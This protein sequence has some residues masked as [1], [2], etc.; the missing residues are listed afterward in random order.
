MFPES[1]VNRYRSER[2][3]GPRP[4]RTC[5]G[6]R[7]SLRFAATGGILV[8]DI[9]CGRR[10][11]QA[12]TLLGNDMMDPYIVAKVT[13]C[14]TVRTA[15]KENDEKPHFNERFVFTISAAD[16]EAGEV[17]LKLFDKDTKTTD[18]EMANVTFT[19]LAPNAQMSE[20]LELVA[21]TA[22]FG[23]S[24]ME[25]VPVLDVN[26][27]LIPIKDLLAAP[28]LL[29]KMDATIKG[30]QASAES[31]AGSAAAMREQLDAMAVDDA[32]DEEAKA[33]L[34]ASL[35]QLE[36][37]MAAAQAADVAALEE[38][39]AAEAA[40]RDELA[41]KI[42]ELAAM[43]AALA[44]AASDDAADDAAKAAQIAG[45]NGILEGTRAQLAQVSA[46]LEAANV[47][48][49]VPCLCAAALALGS[50]LAAYGALGLL[51]WSHTQ[52]FN[53]LHPTQKKILPTRACVFVCL[54][55]IRFHKS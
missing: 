17:T 21:K 14:E 39:A 28:V 12:K 15:A 20:R 31:D 35:A 7:L 6:R 5:T 9:L 48:R 23:A 19:F 8:L 10:F 22:M 25:K 51:R 32:A 33:S 40:A 49:Q 37:D 11:V 2:S 47:R 45:L 36:A 50:P 18:D 52:V 42:E 43:E 30:Q 24:V 4:L 16:M 27:L 54:L 13:G 44:A 1:P 3:L 53:P 55:Q 34:E 38:K 46:Q 41:A 29:A 26:C